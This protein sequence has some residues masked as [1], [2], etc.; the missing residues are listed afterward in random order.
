MPRSVLIIDAISTRRIHLRAQLDT[1]AYPVDLAET[2]SEGLARARKDPPDVVIIADDLPD[3]RLRQFCKT[4]R[5]QKQTQFTTVVV[6]VQSENQSARVS[7][8]VDGAHDVIDMKCDAVDLKARMRSFMRSSDYLSAMDRPAH[9]HIPQGLSESRPDFAPITTATFVAPNP[10]THLFGSLRKMSADAGI[11]ARHAAMHTVRRDPDAESDVY[12]L[13]E[14][15]PNDGIRDTLIALRNHPVSRRSRIL[16]VTDCTSRSASPLDLGADDQVP[17]E[18]SPS[19]LTL[20]ITRLARGKRDADRRSAETQELAQKAYVDALTGLNNRTAM[21]DYLVR[22]DRALADQPKAI[23][24]MIADLDH[25]KAINDS[26]GH[27]AGDVILAKVAQTLK[28]KLRDGD[29]IARY[30]GEEFLIVLPNV[31]R[32]HARDVAMRLRDAV[33]DTPIA[34]TSGTVVRATISIGLAVAHKSERKTTRDLQRAADTALYSAK[35]SG[36]NRIE[37]AQMV[38]PL[39]RPLGGSRAEL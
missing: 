23:A 30:G 27:A 18:I 26:H 39:G 38:S 15:E 21:E 6:A 17:T 2:Q 5:S 14:T 36:R 25:F 31:K 37:L 10:D 16:F 29:F 32:D 4:L 24:V 3:L 7:A 13:F 8:L 22:M 33:A 35:R 11:D 34:L 12:I 1:T 19:E 20:R 28:S 9:G